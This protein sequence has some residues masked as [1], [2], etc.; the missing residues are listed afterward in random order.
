MCA[1]VASIPPTKTSAILIFAVINPLV[2]PSHSIH[3]SFCRDLST[4]VRLPGVPSGRGTPTHC[5]RC[6]SPLCTVTPQDPTDISGTCYSGPSFAYCPSYDARTIPNLSSGTP[7]PLVG[8]K[9]FLKLRPWLL[10]T[11]TN[12]LF[13]CSREVLPLNQLSDSE[14]STS[15]TVLL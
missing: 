2:K 1:T 15:L 8:P 11:I 7:L 10:P 4:T 13:T 12:S 14:K 5:S 3:R 6:L 9:N